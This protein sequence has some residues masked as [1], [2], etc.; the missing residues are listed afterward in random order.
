MSK[1]V[2]IVRRLMEMNR[3]GLT[4]QT[5]GERGL[6]LI[7]PAV[8]FRSR[9]TAIEGTA[10]RGHEGL[11]KYRADMTDAFRE[12]RNEAEAIVE[13]S[14]GT[15]LVQSR[16]HGVGRESGMEVELRSAIVFVLSNGKCARCLA[17]PTRAEALEAAGLSE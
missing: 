10:Y 8:E 9:V 12:W 3:S 11:L 16:F 1:N 15:V 17:Y 4:D 7:D 13:M 2:E 14:P 5:I 6:P